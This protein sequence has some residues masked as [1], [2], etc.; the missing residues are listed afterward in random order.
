MIP[1]A[2]SNRKKKSNEKNTNLAREMNLEKGTLFRREVNRAKG[3]ESTEA[4][5][6]KMKEGPSNEWSS[7]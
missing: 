4:T 5:N 2:L 3:K 1:C 6:L 7:R